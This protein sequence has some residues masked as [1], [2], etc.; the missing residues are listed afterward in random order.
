MGSH[1]KTVEITAPAFVQ[2]VALAIVTERFLLL[3]GKDIEQWCPTSI[4]RIGRFGHSTADLIMQSDIVCPLIQMPDR[5]M[6]ILRSQYLLSTNRYEGLQRI[7][8]LRC[9]IILYMAM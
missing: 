2:S 3:F 1:I 8:D 4:F 5:I 7:E 6:Q 9:S